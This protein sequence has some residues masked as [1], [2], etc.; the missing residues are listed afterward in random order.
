MSE[1]DQLRT[2]TYAPQFR[3]AKALNWPALGI[4]VALV[5]LVAWDLALAWLAFKLC[6]IVF[7]Q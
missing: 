1:F 7:L 4:G 5:S 2:T 3:I 6:R